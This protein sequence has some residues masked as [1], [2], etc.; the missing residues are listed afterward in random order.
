MGMS[1]SIVSTK[2]PFKAVVGMPVGRCVGMVGAGGSCVLHF[3]SI[4]TSLLA[5]PNI[6]YYGVETTGL[7]KSFSLDISHTT[8]QNW[9]VPHPTATAPS[10]IYNSVHMDHH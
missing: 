2:I 6:Q 4:T 5:S 9:L 1:V 3:L 8:E 7:G 10:A